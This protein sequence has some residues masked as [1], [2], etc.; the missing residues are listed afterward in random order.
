MALVL[1]GLLVFGAM[2]FERDEDLAD[3]I[4]AAHVRSLMSGDLVQIGSADPHRVKPWFAGKIDYAPV[5]KD[6]KDEGFT[7]LGGRVDYLRGST[8]AAL[9]YQVRRHKISVFVLPDPGQTRTDERY[10]ESRGF[11][12]VNWHQG[13]FAF[14]AISDLNRDALVRLAKVQARD[15]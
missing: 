11:N 1:G 3:Q 15:R 2:T 12:I 6:A 13:G 10:W 14:W 7:L 9:V 4:V 5:V 8:V